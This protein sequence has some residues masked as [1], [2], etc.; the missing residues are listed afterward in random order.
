MCL[1][2]RPKGEH[3]DITCVLKDLVTARMI[4]IFSCQLVTLLYDYI[5]YTQLDNLHRGY[6]VKID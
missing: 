5:T 1:L 2:L 4:C 3:S 6:I